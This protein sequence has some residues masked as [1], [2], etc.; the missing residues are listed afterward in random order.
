MAMMDDFRRHGV[1]LHG[2]IY[3]AVILLL[4]VVDWAGGGNWWVHWVILGWGAGLA[5]HA[6]AA[7]RA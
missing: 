2:G 5:A 6:W 1:L 4:I 3:A 7:T